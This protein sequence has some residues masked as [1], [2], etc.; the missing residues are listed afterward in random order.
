MIASLPPLAY[1]LWF[2]AAAVNLL[3]HPGSSDT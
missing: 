2:V 3:G 1:A